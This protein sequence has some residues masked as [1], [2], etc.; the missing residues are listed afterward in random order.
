VVDHL[1]LE[2]LNFYPIEASPGH[3]KGARSQRVRV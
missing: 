3:R 2:S 1:L